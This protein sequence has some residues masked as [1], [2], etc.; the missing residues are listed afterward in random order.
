MS[1]GFY[2]AYLDLAASLITLKMFGAYANICLYA[3]SQ[4]H[5]LHY[6]VDQKFSMQ[7]S[8]WQLAVGS[9]TIGLACASIIDVIDCPRYPDFSPLFHLFL[10]DHLKVDYMQCLFA[11][12]Y[13][14]LFYTFNRSTLA[15]Y[16]LAFYVFQQTP[17][18]SLL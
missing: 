13:T 9:C 16:I 10:Y 3:L 5:I 7:V 17:L 18:F 11:L 4:S 15:F 6:F 1:H 8:S 12:H 14:G 2:F